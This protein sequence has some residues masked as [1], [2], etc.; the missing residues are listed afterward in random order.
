[1]PGPM[2]TVTEAIRTADQLNACMHVVLAAEEPFANFASIKGECYIMAML[3]PCHDVP[4]IS[5][6]TY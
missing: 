2:Q 3:S 6:E 4:S 5:C 1:M